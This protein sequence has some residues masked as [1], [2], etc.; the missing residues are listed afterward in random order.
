MKKTAFADSCFSLE[1]VR[2]MRKITVI[3]CVLLSGSSKS[4]TGSG[5]KNHNS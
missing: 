1:V 5:L 2:M 3:L 4:N